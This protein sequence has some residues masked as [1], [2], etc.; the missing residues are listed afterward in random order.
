MIGNYDIHLP[1]L[2]HI[3]GAFQVRI[4]PPENRRTR[5]GDWRLPARGEGRRLFRNPQSAIRNGLG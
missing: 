4:P 5:I 3:P 1:S 2:W